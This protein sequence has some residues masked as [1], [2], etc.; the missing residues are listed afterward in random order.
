MYFVYVRDRFFCCGKSFDQL[1]GVFESDTDAQILR[2]EYRE[3]F[4][5]HHLIEITDSN[6]RVVEIYDGL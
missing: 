4:F 2:E 1:I 6:Q 5:P 3:A